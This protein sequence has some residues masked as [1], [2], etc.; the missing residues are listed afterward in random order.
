MDDLQSWEVFEL[1]NSLQYADATQWEQTRWLM[2]VMAQINS[3]KQLKL[4]DILKFPWDAEAAPTTI[5]DDDIKRLR[6]KAKA[7]GKDLFDG[8]TDI[9][10][11]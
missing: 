2:Y 8:K 5:S 9:Q 6:E 10:H 4:T 1:Y 7:I 11:G 3:R